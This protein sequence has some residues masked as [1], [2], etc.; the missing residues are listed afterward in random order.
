MHPSLIDGTSSGSASAQALACNL[1]SIL[2]FSSRSTADHLAKSLQLKLKNIGTNS[3]PTAST[4]TSTGSS[5]SCSSSKEMTETTDTN[6]NASP[7]QSPTNSLPRLNGTTGL[8]SL[9][10]VPQKHLSP[11]SSSKYLLSKE[12]SITAE[13]E[14]S[15]EDLDEKARM[16]RSSSLKSGKTPPG[17][18]CRKKIVRFAD[19]LGLDLAEV[20]SF[21]DEIPNVPKSAYK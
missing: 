15:D 18:P 12:D 10:A 3:T 17:T 7:T 4:S 19:A 6:N 1:A 13:D 8:S 2:S 21:L 16:R 5:R 11:D 9:L 14:T 20:R